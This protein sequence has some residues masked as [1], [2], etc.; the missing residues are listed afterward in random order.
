MLTVYAVLHPRDIA[1]ATGVGRV[2]VGHLQGLSERANI[3]VVPIISEKEYVDF[4]KPLPNEWVSLRKKLIKGDLNSRSLACIIFNAPRLDLNSSMYREQRVLLCLDESYIAAKGVPTVVMIHDVAWL[5]DDA[6]P[7]GLLRARKRLRSRMLLSRLV[8]STAAVLTVSEFSRS[9]IAM[10]EPRLANKLYV[11]P[12]FLRQPFSSY[13]P[14]LLDQAIPVGNT[15]PYVYLPGGLSYRKNA[16]LVIDAWSVFRRL[17]P[18]IP[19]LVSGVSDA[20]YIAQLSRE[21][22]VTMLGFTSDEALVHLYRQ[23]SV[24]WLPSRYEGFGM[25]ALEAMSQGT[26]VVASDIPAVREVCADAAVTAHPRD[27]NGHA[28][29][30]LRVLDE[31]HLRQKLSILGLQRVATYSLKRSTDLL[32][33]CLTKAAQAYACS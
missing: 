27:A 22:N 16:Q 1:A 13:T 5:D 26:P 32:V 14:Q 6:H 30:L 15:Q 7:A 33:E 8:S 11:V 20:K 29:A 23:A 9:R 12:N 4:G 17:R 3:N 28:H 24:V 2:V 25:S 21:P 19:L 18:D 10:H 31:Q